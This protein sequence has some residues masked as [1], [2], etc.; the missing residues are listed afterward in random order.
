MK[1]TAF[2]ASFAFVFVSCEQIDLIEPSGLEVDIA[3]DSIVFAHIGD[4]GDA[5]AAELSV[6]ELVKS[7]NPDFIISSGDNNYT[8]GQF[9]SLASNITSYY[10][11]Y[12]YNFDATPSYQCG[13]RAFTDKINRF[14]PTPGNH[15][16][17]SNDGLI[18]Y[19]NFFTLPGNERFYKFSWGPVTFYSINSTEENLEEQKNWLKNELMLSTRSFNIVFTHHPPYS[20]GPHGNTERMQWDFY[21]LGIDLLFAGHDHV[22]SRVEKNGEEGLV[23]IVNGLGGRGVSECYGTSIPDLG[24][25]LCF[26]GEYGAVKGIATKDNLII[27][28]YAVNRPEHPVDRFELNHESD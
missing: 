20:L 18:P 27:E 15:D 28:F 17:Y 8:R 3:S 2:F 1:L 14:F 16:T 26:G 10:G 7:W 11:D 13:G 22:Y 6:S 12:I 21:S 4:Y 9:S 19:Y 24:Q 25:S 23:Y 5:G